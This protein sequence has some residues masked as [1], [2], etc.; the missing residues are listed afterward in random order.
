MLPASR[1]TKPFIA[2]LIRDPH[3][4][5]L[6]LCGFAAEPIVLANGG[7]DPIAHRPLIAA[8]LWRIVVEVGAPHTQ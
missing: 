8:P 6:Q 1:R 4:P 3:T 5:D 7:E 2:V